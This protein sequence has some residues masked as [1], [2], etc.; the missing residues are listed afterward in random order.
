SRFDNIF[1]L[2]FV[3]SDTLITNDSTFTNDT[4]IVSKKMIITN[5][6]NLLINSQNYSLS[7]GDTAFYGNELVGGTYSRIRF[8]CDYVD[9][10]Q[11]SVNLSV[12]IKR[13]TQD[14]SNWR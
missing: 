2:I 9:I 1:L 13:F 5:S 10:N 8:S 6:C 3:K 14:C 7:E 4:L 12:W 11:E